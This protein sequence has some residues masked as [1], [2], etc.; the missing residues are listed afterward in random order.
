VSA[1]SS[2]SHRGLIGPAPTLAN[3]STMTRVSRRTV[4]GLAT[5]GLAVPLLASCSGDD[6]SS[7]TGAASGDGLGSTSDVEVGGGTIF[8]D[9][10][11]V[12]TQPAAGT[13]KGFDTTCT[14]QGCQVADVTDGFI[15]CPCHNSRFAIDTGEPTDDSQATSPLGEVALAV[16]GDRISVA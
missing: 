15:R 1:F 13:F 10:Q 3:V 6:P 4:T 14:H 16:E 9:Q 12:V 8:A 2:N 5:A 11:V 7:A